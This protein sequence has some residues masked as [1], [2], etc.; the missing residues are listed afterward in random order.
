MADLILE[1]RAYLRK[2]LSC[3][4]VEEQRIVAEAVFA[5]F[6]EEYASVN[7]AVGVDLGAVGQDEHHCAGKMSVALI[8]GN[9][10]QIVEKLLTVFGIVMSAAGIA[11]GAYARLAVKRIDTEPR[12]VGQDRIAGEQPCA[13]GSL[14]PRVAHEAVGILVHIKLDMRLNG[15]K[16][17]DIDRPETF[18]E[19]LQWLKLHNRR[20]E[21]TMMV[22]KLKVRDYISSAIGE[23]YLVPLI[24]AWDNPDDI[25]FASLPD[26]FVLKCNPNSGT[27]MCICKDKSSLDT[28]KVRRGLRKGLR[29]N[30]YDYSR[31]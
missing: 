23:E 18:S 4:L 3:R 16:H 8:Q 15:R 19:K 12:I 26:K 11:C 5:L 24:G 1:C 2:G 9:I 13:G 28:E 29:Q 17:F 10:S 22:D 31:E 7:G 30:Y 27:G 14:Q 25:D 6:A 20:D 21:Y